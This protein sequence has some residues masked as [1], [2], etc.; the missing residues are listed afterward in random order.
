MHLFK[1]LFKTNKLENNSTHL[2][3]KIFVQRSVSFL[4]N[5][6]DDSKKSNFGI[7]SIKLYFSKVNSKT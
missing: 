6:N 1:L 3:K 5:I 2:Q 7:V 4:L